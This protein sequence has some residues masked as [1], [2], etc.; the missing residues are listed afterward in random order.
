MTVHSLQNR[1][2]SP[3][4]TQVACFRGFASAAAAEADAAL[5][6]GHQGFAVPNVKIESLRVD[7]AFTEGR[8]RE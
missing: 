8:P 1:L 7:L 2:C 5:M 3:E 4:T 6:D